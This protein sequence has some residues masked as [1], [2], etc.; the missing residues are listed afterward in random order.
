MQNQPA[1]PKEGRNRLSCFRCGL[2]PGSETRR[3]AETLKNVNRNSKNKT[4]REMAK[5]E[6]DALGQPITEVEKP[7]KRSGESTK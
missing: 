3:R 6:N 5:N 2:I 1:K 4:N 7:L